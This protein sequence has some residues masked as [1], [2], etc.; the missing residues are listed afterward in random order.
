MSNVQ[1]GD[2][3][4][5]IEMKGEPHYTGKEGVVKFI[6]DIGQLHGTWGGCAII[7]EEDRF[8]IIRKAN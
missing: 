1:V 3:L 2:T 7:S 6:D 5:I 8:E 4:R